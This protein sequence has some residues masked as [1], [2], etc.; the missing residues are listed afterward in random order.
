MGGCR[1]VGY[2]PGGIP[3]ETEGNMVSFLLS[4]IVLFIVILL[5]LR[6]NGGMISLKFM[7]SSIG[8]IPFPSV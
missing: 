4:L 8:P 3:P 6:K 7:M 5:G 1:L 2:I